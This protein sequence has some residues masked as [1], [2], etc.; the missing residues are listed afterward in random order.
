MTYLYLATSLFFA[1]LATFTIGGM[2]N[3]IF[4]R[5]PAIVLCV[6][7]GILAAKGFGLI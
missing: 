7:Y 6:V 2:R 5:F 1:F 3:N 4:V